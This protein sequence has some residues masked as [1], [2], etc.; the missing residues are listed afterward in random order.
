MRGRFR[1]A[2]AGCCSCNNVIL[3]YTCSLILEERFT[4]S[5][6]TGSV[7]VPLSESMYRFLLSQVDEI[8]SPFFKWQNHLEFPVATI[9][10]FPQFR[11]SVVKIC[12]NAANLL[13]SGKKI[14]RR[15]NAALCE[16]ELGAVQKCENIIQ[17]RRFKTYD[18]FQKKAE[19]PANHITS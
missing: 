5:L 2:R 19:K 6:V 3:H 17:N 16:I 11:R 14:H 8:Q 18:C 4:Y 1:L 9:Q 12:G 7:N 13:K 15:K 10:D